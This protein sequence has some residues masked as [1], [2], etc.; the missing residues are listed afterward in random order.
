MKSSQQKF[1]FVFISIWLF[2]LFLYA[3]SKRYNLPRM[4][5]LSDSCNGIWRLS[6]G[7]IFSTATVLRLT[8]LSSLGRRAPC[9][10][11]CICPGVI[12]V[13]LYSTTWFDNQLTVPSLNKASPFQFPRYN[14]NKKKQSVRDVSI[15]VKKDAFL[16]LNNKSASNKHFLFSTGMLAAEPRWL[17]QGSVLRSLICLSRKSFFLWQKQSTGT[18]A[19]K[20]FLLIELFECC[21]EGWRLWRVVSKVANRNVH[22]KWKRPI[23]GNNLFKFAVMFVFLIATLNCFN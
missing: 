2:L 3:P 19:Q 22:W 20:W 21:R 10:W 1:Q 13:T 7:D 6:W 17:L 8:P 9:S 16:F 15:R 12:S 23:K 14:N 18:W 11:G 5:I 4:K